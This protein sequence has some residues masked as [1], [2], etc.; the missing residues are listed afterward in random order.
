MGSGFE[1]REAYVEQALFTRT[2]FLDHVR[3]AKSASWTSAYGGCSTPGLYRVRSPP[4]MS[5]GSGRPIAPHRA[6]SRPWSV[7]SAGADAVCGVAQLDDRSH[8][9]LGGSTC[10]NWRGGPTPDLRKRALAVTSSSRTAP[11]WLRG[12]RGVLHLAAGA[13]CCAACPTGLPRPRLPGSGTPA[14]ATRGPGGRT[15]QGPVAGVH[16]S[17]AVV[18][19]R[20]LRT[21]SHSRVYSLGHRRL[22]STWGPHEPRPVRRLHLDRAVHRPRHHVR[23]HPTRPA[24]SRTRT[25]R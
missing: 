21:F 15:D 11:F 20:S 6:T 19:A 2:C 13:S 16:P 4:W 3:D 12:G 18:W 8:A 1:P 10:Q 14:E 22:C 5:T 24:N 7:G 25:P 9:V 23:R 17:T